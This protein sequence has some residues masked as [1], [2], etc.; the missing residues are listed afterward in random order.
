MASIDGSL[1]IVEEG[2]SLRCSFLLLK[3]EAQ[4]RRDA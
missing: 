4:R 1:T 2:A 3:A